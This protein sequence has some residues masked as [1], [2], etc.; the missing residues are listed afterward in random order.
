[1]KSSRTSATKMCREVV[2]RWLW[3]LCFLGGVDGALDR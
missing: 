3:R 1:M 2:K